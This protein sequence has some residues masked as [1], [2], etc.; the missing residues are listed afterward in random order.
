MAQYNA[1]LGGSGLKW[2]MNS[3]LAT[4]APGGNLKYSGHIPRSMFTLPFWMDGG[5]EEWRE[6]MRFATPQGQGFSVG[7]SVVMVYAPGTHLFGGGVFHL[8]KDLP[9]GIGLTITIES[10]ADEVNPGATDDYTTKTLSIPAGS[11]AGFVFIPAPVDKTSFSPFGAKAS[12][13]FTGGNGVN[14]GQILDITQVCFEFRYNATDFADT[15]VCSNEEPTCPTDY[16]DAVSSGQYPANISDFSVPASAV[17]EAPS[18]SKTAATAPASASD[19]AATTATTSTGGST[20][21]AS[22][23]TGTASKN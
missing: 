1:Y 17:S 5:R 20:G 13:S 7:D 18:S 9:T 3:T 12:I 23:S 6:F 2:P 19:A 15:K 14:A 16:P 22:N 10:I 4:G 21:S 11:Q 8:K